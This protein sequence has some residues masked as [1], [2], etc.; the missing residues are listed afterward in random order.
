MILEFQA[1]SSRKPRGHH[2]E[3]RLNISKTKWKEPRHNNPRASL[4]FRKL[5]K[6]DS[7]SNNS[8]QHIM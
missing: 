6:K 3:I 8:K 1:N 4:R 7:A 2:K 5:H